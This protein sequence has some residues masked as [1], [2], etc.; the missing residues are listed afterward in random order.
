MEL[1]FARSGTRACASM[2]IL[3][4]SHIVVLRSTDQAAFAVGIT[5]LW[6]A[7]VQSLLPSPLLG[8]GVVPR[9]E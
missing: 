1:C 3:A 6:S 9:R 8:R 4:R 2:A 5:P 7:G